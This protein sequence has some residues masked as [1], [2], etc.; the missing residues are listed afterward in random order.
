MKTVIKE[1]LT[2]DELATYVN[3]YEPAVNMVYYY[4]QTTGR[5]S[6]VLNPDFDIDYWIER[7]E[8]KSNVSSN[9][10]LICFSDV[11]GWFAR[12]KK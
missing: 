11:I 4:L 8:I 7:L 5:M 12:A 6:F 9:G 2:F 3:H 10:D 1:I